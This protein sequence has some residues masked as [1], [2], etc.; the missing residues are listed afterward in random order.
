MATGFDKMFTDKNFNELA[1]MF[2]LFKRV[3]S[4][5]EI[6]IAK[7]VPYIEERG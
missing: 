5:L 7:M 2:K 4:S 1:M 3:E 6:M